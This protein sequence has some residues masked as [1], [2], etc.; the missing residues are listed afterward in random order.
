MVFGNSSN[1]T[2]IWRLFQT[3]WVLLRQGRLWGEMTCRCH[4]V[5]QQLCQEQKIQ[6]SHKIQGPLHCPTWWVAESCLCC[7]VELDD[8]YS[9]FHEK[10]FCDSM[11]CLVY[12]KVLGKAWEC[13]PIHSWRNMWLATTGALQSCPSWPFLLQRDENSHLQLKPYLNRYSL[14]RGWQQPPAEA[15]GHSTVEEHSSSTELQKH[16]HS[17]FTLF[18]LYLY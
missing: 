11:T 2:G 17:E 4:P 10:P 3:R 18:W 14:W 8:L 13:L 9:L 16:I 5:G 6:R 15:A 12:K 1:N 7:E